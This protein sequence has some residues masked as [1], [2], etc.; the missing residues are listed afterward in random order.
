MTGTKETKGTKGTTARSGITEISLL[1]LLSLLSLWSSNN[2]SRAKRTL[3]L[4]FHLSVC[5][6]RRHHPLRQGTDRTLKRALLLLLCCFYLCFA[7]K[8]QNHLPSFLTK[9]YQRNTL[10]GYNGNHRVVTT[11]LLRDTYLADVG[12]QQSIV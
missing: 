9:G 5:M 8:Q 6:R 4:S 11:H 3:P 12:Y 2:Q 7:T 1:S 10:L